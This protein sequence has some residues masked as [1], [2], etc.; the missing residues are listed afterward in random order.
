MTWLAVA[1]LLLHARFSSQTL[2][3]NSSWRWTS[4]RSNSILVYWF[5]TREKLVVALV[6]HFV[7]QVLTNLCFRNPCHQDLTNYVKCR[8]LDISN[9]RTTNSW[10]FCE[11]SIFRHLESSYDQFLTNFLEIIANMTNMGQKD[12]PCWTKKYETHVFYID[13]YVQNTS[14]YGID[15]WH[16]IIIPLSSTWTEK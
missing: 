13:S 4:T 14:K 2:L 3:M 5:T 16:I 7:V 8:Y 1:V 15:W 12:F 9:H 10:P 11:I 6:G